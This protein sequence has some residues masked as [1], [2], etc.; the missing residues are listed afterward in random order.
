MTKTIDAI[1]RRLGAKRIAKV[2]DAGGGAFGTTRPSNSRIIL[3]L[4]PEEASF[5]TD[6]K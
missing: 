4:R 3:D 6:S 1:T 2:P 5:G